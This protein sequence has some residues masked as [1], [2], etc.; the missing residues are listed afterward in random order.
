MNKAR[1]LLPLWVVGLLVLAAGSPACKTVPAKTVVAKAPVEAP[2]KPTTQPQLPTLPDPPPPQVLSKIQEKP[3]FDPVDAVIKESQAYFLEGEKD[4]KAGFLER[5]RRNF[6]MSLEVVLRAGI[7]INQQER[8]ERHL[9]GLIDRI[10][11]YEL[12]AL[13]EGDGFTE[14]NYESAPIDEFASGDV[15]LTFDPRSKVLAEET[16]KQVSHDLPLVINDTVLRFLDYLQNRGR[17]GMEAGMQRAGR[18][19]AMIS[20]I[21]A[22]EGVPQ[23]LIYLC[24]AESS[25]KPLALSNKKCKGMWQF[26]AWR[27]QYYGLRQNWWI[28]ERS[29][30]EKSTRA[31]ARH[32]KDLY[33]Q[34]GD[35]FLAMAA[36]NTGPGNVERAIE[37]TGFADY[38]ELVRRGTLHPDTV[39]YVPM[40]LAMV[41]VSKDPAKYGFEITPDP[42][43]SVDHVQIDSAIDLRLAAESLDIGLSDLK[44]LNP[45]VRRLTTPRNDPEFTLYL[46]AGSK[47]KFLQEIASIPEEMRVTWRMHRVEDGE[48][49]SIIAKKYHTT[50]SAI[51]QVNSLTEG[52][53]IQ[54]DEKLIIP[55]TAGRGKVSSPAEGLLIRYTLKRGDTISSVAKEFEVT[56]AQVRKWNR[57]GVKSKL[58]PGR[59]LVI[60]PPD[61]MAQGDRKVPE[62]KSARNATTAN[63][64]RVIHQVKK[65]ETLFAIAA[66]YRI[67]INSIRDWNNLSESENLKVG[68]KLT[69]YLNR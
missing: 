16:L 52:Q 33:D 27:G 4:L 11:N 63:S 25:F 21:L 62:P 40:I 42:T 38:W 49:L 45:H 28:D 68:D 26:D 54:V 35:W 44:D 3:T 55:V 65:G 66:N 51:S 1:E 19:R 31:A 43:I 2:P 10:H 8:L 48:T 37:R 18:Y 50:P 15:P 39:S 22:E 46:P 17:R 47:E 67:P 64:A 12:A 36:Y 13:R 53:R 29:D 5:A 56:V 23:D 59:V 61:T 14:E 6:D 60:Y 24:Q 20:E 69:I 34:F 30:P 41:I 32:L 7:A 9:E 58:S 57:L